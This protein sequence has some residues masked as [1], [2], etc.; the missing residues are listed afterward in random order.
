MT[1]QKTIEA[2][3]SAGIY[4]ATFDDLPADQFVRSR[5]ELLDGQ[6]T[7]VKMDHVYRVRIDDG[8]SPVQEVIWF[9]KITTGRTGIGNFVQYQE[10]PQDLC[11][12]NEP[13]L[14]RK[15][16]YDPEKEDMKEVLVEDDLAK[17]IVHYDYP[18]NKENIAMVGEFTKKN[19]ETYFYVLDL[20]SNRG[21]IV[22]NFEDWSSKPFEELLWPN[23]N[24]QQ[25]AAA[26]AAVVAGQDSEIEALRE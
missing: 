24:R 16:I 9:T 6:K 8:I 10:T 4:Q 7:E 3:K 17:T 25:Q 23:R 20:R 21:V 13:I 18:F 2:R 14:S 1:H 12:W 11:I 5:K 19:R 15:I 22:N 26:A